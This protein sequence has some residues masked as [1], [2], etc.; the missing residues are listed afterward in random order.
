MGDDTPVA[1]FARTPRPLYAFF[2]QRFAQVTNPPI[3]P[4]RESLVM[5]LRTW[6]GPRPDLLQLE[7]PHGALIELRSPVIDEATLA[8][9]RAQT[10]MR[11][12]EIDA[13]FAVD[14]PTRSLESIIVELCDAAE[15]AARSGA[16]LVV[17]SDRGVGPSRAPVPMLLALGAVHQRLLQTGLRTLVDLVVEA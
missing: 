12:V 16:Q 7:G 17:I 8:A 5:S 4:L 9:L 6:L 14:D 11:V 1:P 3:D 2:R 13:T 15:S 10:A